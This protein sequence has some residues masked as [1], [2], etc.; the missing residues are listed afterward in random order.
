[1]QDVQ[2]MFTLFYYFKKKKKKKKKIIYHEHP[3]HPEQSATFPFKINN[4]HLLN[5]YGGIKSRKL[6]ILL[7]FL[8]A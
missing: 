3:A 1:V 8:T 2:G 6:L 4:L 5:T 7:G